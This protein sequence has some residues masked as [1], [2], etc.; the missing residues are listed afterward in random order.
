V[1][2]KTGVSVSDYYIPEHSIIVPIEEAVRIVRTI[3]HKTGT[4]TI[5]IDDADG[6]TLG[7]TVYAPDNMPG[8]DRS[9]MDGYAIITGDTSDA[10]KENPSILMIAGLVQKGIPGPETIKS[11]YAIAIQTGGLLP[12]GSDA[13][14]MDEDCIHT[15]NEIYILKPISAGENII[16]HDEDFKK[17]EPVYQEGWILRPQDIG[18]LASLGKIRVKVRK[19]P[20]IGIISTGREL[21][22]SESIPR[23]GEVREVNSYLIAAFCRRQGALPVRYGII[24]DDISELTR[25]LQ[26]AAQECD[27]VIVSGGS[28]RDQN[29]VTARVIHNLGEVFTEGISF[30]PDKRTTIGRINTVLVIGLPGHP[31]ATYMV[32]TLVVIHLIQAMKGS[33]CQRVY[34]IRAKLADHLYAFKQSDRYI[35]VSLNDGIAVPVFGKAGLIN[36]LS[37]SDGIVRIPGGGAGYRAGDMVEVMIW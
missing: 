14:V 7:E 37:L 12:E 24:R 36:M 28:A 27:T 19:R 29:D 22:P 26:H 15:G 31:S 33:P 16:R 8:F 13:V 1:S 10:T 23:S 5:S 2:P 9:T 32:L 30:A 11:G 18:V 34:R 25:L 21:V 35:R 3:A 17:D 20:V 4:E 6:R